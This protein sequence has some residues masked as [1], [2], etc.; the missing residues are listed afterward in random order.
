MNAGNKPPEQ[1]DVAAQL[2]SAPLPAYAIEMERRLVILETRFDAIL[3]TLATKADLA[4]LRS[5]LLSRMEV[6]RADLRGDFDTLCGDFD[7]LRADLSNQFMSMMKWVIGIFVVSTIGTVISVNNMQARGSP[8]A[9][10]AQ[11]GPAPSVAST[12]KP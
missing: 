7:K 12:P 5:E 2:A 6:V 10:A 8:P 1:D 9:V 4:E 3:P 11:P